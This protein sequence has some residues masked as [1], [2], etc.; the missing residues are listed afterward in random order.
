MRIKTIRDIKNAL[1]KKGYNCITIR[2]KSTGGIT[3]HQIRNMKTYD[4]ELITSKKSNLL[5]FLRRKK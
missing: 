1:S 2:N 3:N 4:I 5:K